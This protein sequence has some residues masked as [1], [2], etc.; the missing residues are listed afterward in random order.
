M[1]STPL[2]TC[3]EQFRAVAHIRS[4]RQHL[5]NNEEEK[6]YFTWFKHADLILTS[7]G[8]QLTGFDEPVETIIL[9]RTTKSLTLYYQMIG[10]WF[11]KLQ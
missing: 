10:R 6:R 4:F 5:S 7:V 8:L 2:Y 11:E 1:E 9:N 3:G